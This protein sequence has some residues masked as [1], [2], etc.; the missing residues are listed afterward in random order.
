MREVRSTTVIALK[1][2]G[3]SVMGGDGQ[4]T[5]GDIV[6]KE[7]ARK[8]RRLYNG[9]V[10]A[11]FAGATA[12]AM[13]L[14]ERFEGKLEEYQ[15]NLLRAAVEMAKDWRTDKVLRRLEALLVVMDREKLL[16]ISGTGDIV[17][18]DDNVIA[19]GSGGAYALA[20][21]KALMA[22]SNLSAE[23]IVREALRIA[24]ALCIYTNNNFIIEKL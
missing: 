14:L 6:L 17:E 11:G 24:S 23:E 7:S 1:H 10:L 20:A 5:M 8:V 22:H 9:R 3:E 19:V 15:G 4:V 18:P 2:K 13:T 16:L 21:A 12:D